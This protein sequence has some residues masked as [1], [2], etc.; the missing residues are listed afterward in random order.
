MRTSPPGSPKQQPPV[1]RTPPNGAEKCRADVQTS[2]WE[3]EVARSNRVTRTIQTENRLFFAVFR[4][5]LFSLFIW[6]TH[7]DRL[8]C[9]QKN[10]RR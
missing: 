9:G 7:Y 5:L 10:S 4:P 1:D 3:Q 2:V 6:L 8:V